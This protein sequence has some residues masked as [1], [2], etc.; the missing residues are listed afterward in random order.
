MGMPGNV[1]GG[2][3]TTL[4]RDGTRQAPRVHDHITDKNAD[5]SQEAKDH[6]KKMLDANKDIA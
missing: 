3:K 1:I 6:A 4:E 2:Y 5:V